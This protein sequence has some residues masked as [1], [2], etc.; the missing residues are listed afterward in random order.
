MFTN[1]ILAG[2]EALVSCSLTETLLGVVS[3]ETLPLELITFVTRAVRVI[4]IMTSLDANGFTSCS[5]MS[6]IVHRLI[7]SVSEIFDKVNENGGVNIPN[8]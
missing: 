7:V 2:G 5:G 4:D 6:I 3:C 1:C 8:Q